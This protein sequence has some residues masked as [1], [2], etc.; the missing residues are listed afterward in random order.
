MGAKKQR[1]PR[2]EDVAMKGPSQPRANKISPKALKEGDKLAKFKQQQHA[3]TVPVHSRTVSIRP[4]TPLVTFAS[5]SNLLIGSRSVAEVQNDIIPPSAKAQRRNMRSRSNSEPVSLTDEVVSIPVASS[6]PPKPRAKTPRKPRR[7]PTPHPKKATTATA[8]HPKL[9][10]KSESLPEML[11]F[12]PLSELKMPSTLMSDN[13]A[14]IYEPILP[15]NAADSVDQGA[16]EWPIPGPASGHHTT[17]LSSDEHA[18]DSD[19]LSV[20][21][22]C[23]AEDIN[24]PS[25]LDFAG[26][27]SS[28]SFQSSTSFGERD[29][30][31]MLPVGMECFKI[32]ENA[33][34]MT[35]TH[36]FTMNE[37]EAELGL[38]AFATLG[39]DW[40]NA[41]H[42]SSH[43]EKMSVAQE[44]P[45]LRSLG[46]ATLRRKES[47]GR[48]RSTSDPIHTTALI[49]PTIQ[50][51]SSTPL[52]PMAIKSDASTELSIQPT[53]RN[54]ILGQ[55]LQH[56]ESSYHRWLM[57]G[58][59]EMEDSSVK[60]AI[61]VSTEAGVATTGNPQPSS[62]EL[63]ELL[64]RD[65]AVE[66]GVASDFEANTGVNYAL[67]DG[68]MTS[69]LL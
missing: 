45:P 46:E 2:G 49:H 38:N 5:D 29:D 1:K 57:M 34:L 30:T 14:N 16:F 15:S 52:E 40:Q 11:P 10:S 36:E 27:P 59:T 26:P 69:T 22:N 67:D 42:L 35:E 47:V 4:A 54:E 25:V 61:W 66:W 64:I 63:D 13:E 51:F 33:L 43:L 3:I 17:S 18:I 55:Q 60:Q 44:D 50:R 68:G 20:L 62:Q 19:I 39:D 23:D 53:G 37:P 32:S 28:S 41:L 12:E 6:N 21:A 56:H 8:R 48:L 7:T 31:E 65:D 9:R 58:P 24:D